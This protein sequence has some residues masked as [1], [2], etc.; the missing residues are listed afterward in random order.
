MKSILIE[1][2]ELVHGDRGADY[3]HPLDD[4][5]RT[6]GAVSALLAHKLKEPLTAEDV[7]VVMICVKLSRE[8]NVP[9]RDNR[10]DGAGYFE[11][12]DM[13]VNERARRAGA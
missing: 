1:A 6:A 2:H 10:L 8:M 3:G 13:V 11:T 4:F 12:L 5:G 7:A 9:K